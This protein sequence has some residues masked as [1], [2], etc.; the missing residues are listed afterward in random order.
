MFPFSAIVMF[1]TILLLFRFVDVLKSL[2][3]NIPP[4]K[5][6]KSS[7]Q[8]LAIHPSE[9]SLIVAAGDKKGKISKTLCINFMT[10]II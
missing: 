10:L 5:V 8:S 9:T 2:D 7:I 4:I 3:M 6:T 1:Y